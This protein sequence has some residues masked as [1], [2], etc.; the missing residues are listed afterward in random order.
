MQ[1]PV[2]LVNIALNVPMILLFG[3]WGA[4][5]ATYACDGLLAVVLWGV[6]LESRRRLGGSEPGAGDERTRPPRQSISARG[7]P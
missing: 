7:K 4:V 2:A 5:W 6:V 1:V 3:Y